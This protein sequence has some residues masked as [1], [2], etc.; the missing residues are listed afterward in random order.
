MEEQECWIGIKY[1]KLGIQRPNS[2]PDSATGYVTLDKALIFPEP[3][4]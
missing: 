4:S 2:H 1:I 3:V